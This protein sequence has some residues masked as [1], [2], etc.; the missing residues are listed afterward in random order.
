MTLKKL[1]RLLLASSVL[2]LFLS[3][4]L[5]SCQIRL[6]DGL[7]VSPQGS[8]LEFTNISVSFDSEI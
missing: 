4:F 2:I 3:A 7:L 6:A 1:A 8:G 5:V